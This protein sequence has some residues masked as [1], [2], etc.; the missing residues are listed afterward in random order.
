MKKYVHLQ[1]TLRKL[2]LGKGGMFM[3]IDCRIYVYIYNYT[4]M[5]GTLTLSL[6]FATEPYLAYLRR[7]SSVRKALFWE[8]H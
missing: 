8:Y 1:I 3:T 4:G 5:H 7:I 6:H 2:S